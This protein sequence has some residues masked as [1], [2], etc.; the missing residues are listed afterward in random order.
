VLGLVAVAALAASDDPHRWLEDPEDEAVAA[1]RD[2]RTAEALDWLGTEAL[3]ERVAEL[4]ALDEARGVH[5]SAQ[6]HRGGTTIWARF[7]EHE[8]TAEQ[9]AA[10]AEHDQRTV[11][12][13]LSLYA[14]GPGTPVPG[15]PL[16]APGVLPDAS[17]CS[18]EPSHD[19][20]RVVWRMRPYER[21]PPKKRRPRVCQTWTT[22]LGT[23]EV[24]YLGPV[25]GNIRFDPADADTLWV[26]REDARG[27][28]TRLERM[29]LATG[30]SEDVERARRGSLWWS[31]MPDGTEV[32]WRRRGRRLKVRW[33]DEHRL[34]L[35]Q[36]RASWAG[37][38]DGRLLLRHRDRD[39]R[40]RVVSVDPARPG[41]RHWQELAVDTEEARFVSVA[42]HQGSLLLG[43]DHDGSV[44]L[45]E[46]P[47]DAGDEAPRHP[48]D[49]RFGYVWA[50][51]TLEPVTL[52]RGHRPQ[53]PQVWLRDAKGTYTELKGPRFAEHVAF[54]TVHVTAP[55]GTDIPVSLQRPHQLDGP[56][57]LWVR[58]YGGF[59]NATRATGGLLDER[60]VAAGGIVATVHAR[61]GNERGDAWHEA[62]TKRELAVTYA[63]V[64]HAVLGLVEQGLAERGR[65]VISGTSNGGLTAVATMLR[66][67]EL[68]AGVIAGAGVFDLLRGPAMGRWWPKE[69]G[70]PSVAAQREVLQGL[71][72][73]HATPD[74]LP[75]VWLVTGEEDPTVTPSHSYKLAAAWADVEGGPV[76]LRATPWPSHLHHLD[77]DE[78]HEAVNAR[79]VDAGERLLAEQELFVQ[80]VL[81]LEL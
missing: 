20:T 41:R 56:A 35:P 15:V 14:Q 75:P 34:R 54:E 47:V 81:G 70:S 2:E 37:W 55:D 51:R 38:H 73:V 46:R 64:H 72:P 30:T 29:D 76:L 36:R 79:P 58:V 13:D 5:L 11:R 3:D 19:G 57:P 10:R 42:A 16:E 12:W 9:L 21:V 68:F 59:G 28:R 39:D 49:G 33:G 71:S 69:Y 18:V 61:G 74:H 80:R 25:R 23:G 67:P 8:L 32:L 66:D 60:F 50:G 44:T 62:A 65:V 4:V 6:D 52:V 43:V 48:L 7:V 45:E 31:R 40:T 77:D 24:R 27:R 78:R 22:E 1:W 17:L 53:G 63:D 26:M